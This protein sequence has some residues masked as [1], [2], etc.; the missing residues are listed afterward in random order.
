MLALIVVLDERGQR[1][2]VVV[3]LVEVESA[4]GRLVDVVM[5]DLRPDESAA[6]QGEDVVLLGAG[7]ADEKAAIFGHLIQESLSLDT[8][9]CGGIKPTD[10]EGENER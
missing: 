9:D 8:V 1:W 10:W 7:D 4:T 6:V 2:I 3:L 5:D